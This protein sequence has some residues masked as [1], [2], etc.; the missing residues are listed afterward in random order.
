[1][2]KL[3]EAAAGIDIGAKKIFVSVESEPVKSFDTFTEDFHKAKDYLLSKGIK[4][5][6]M[7]ATGVYWKE[8][9]SAV[10]TV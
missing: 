10:V 7:E 2:K 5:V 1:M 6:A 4:T 8:P 3:R 9:F